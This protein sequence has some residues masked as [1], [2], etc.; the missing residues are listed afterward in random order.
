MQIRKLSLPGPLIIKPKVFS[1]KRGFLYDMWSLHTYF[2]SGIKSKFV[3]VI[4]SY[5]KKNTLR[6]IHFQYPNL[7]GRLISIINGKIFD[8]TI[9]IE[10]ILA[11]NNNSG[12]SS[13]FNDFN[14]NISVKIDKTYIDK[15]SYINNLSGSINFTKNKK[16]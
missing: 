8:A 3:E 2:K 11:S 6:G 12:V 13:I 15:I 14:S 1:D 5:S 7:Q 4:H 10:K 9:L 16:Q